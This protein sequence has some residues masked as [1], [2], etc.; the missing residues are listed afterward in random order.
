MVSQSYG[1]TTIVRA[2]VINRDPQA[3]RLICQILLRCGYAVSECDS[4]LF[5]QDEYAG[6]SLVVVD[7]RSVNDEVRDFL[8]WVKTQ[9]VGS[10]GRQPYVMAVVIGA[11]IDW[12]NHVDRSDWDEMLKM[13]D[14]VDLLRQRFEDIGSRFTRLEVA[15]E[16]LD[17]VSPF[18]LDLDS[19]V[20]EKFSQ[21]EAGGEDGSGVELSPSRV[22]E[23]N[24]LRGRASTAG[25]LPCQELFNEIAESVPY[26]LVVLGRDEKFIY[27]NARHAELLGLGIDE[28]ESMEAWLQALCAEEKTCREVTS[29]WRRHV[30]QKQLV[31][32]YTLRAV[33]GEM[34]DIEFRPKLLQDGGLLLTMI[35]VSERCRSEEA[36]L[37][38]EVKFKT[39]FGS[40][41]IGMALVDRT[42]RICT[43]NKALEQML[44]YTSVELRAMAFDD[45]V[46]VEDSGTKRDFE[47]L[48]KEEPQLAAEEVRLS[49]RK[50]GGG[51]LKVFLSIARMDEKGGPFMA[52]LVRADN[53][54]G[55]EQVG[56][57]NLQ[58]SMLQNRALLEAVPDLVILFDYSGKVEDVSPADQDESF[59]RKCS[60]WTGRPLEEV[61]PAFWKVCEN[62]GLSEL[63]FHSNEGL[64]LEF[65]PAEGGVACA[66]VAGCGRGKYMAVIRRKEQGVGGPDVIASGVLA[67]SNEADAKEVI[68]SCEWAD[69]LQTLTSLL[70]LE[71][72]A[73]PADP[74]KEKRSVLQKHQGR[75]RAIACLRAARLEPVNGGS[76]M[77]SVP[78]YLK[79]LL[80]ELLGS[81]PIVSDK[82]IEA[83]VNCVSL[84]LPARKAFA[85]G[86]YVTE[87]VSNSIEHGLANF[88][89]GQVY[90]RLR[91]SDR[92][93]VLLIGD[94]GEGLPAEF[95]WERANTLGFRVVKSL[96]AQLGARLEIRPRENTE[97]L[98][99]FPLGSD[100]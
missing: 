19:E 77:V 17:L 43:V 92:E 23:L 61:L 100:E 86:L 83:E 80:E 99:R 8:A 10:E 96:V 42:G 81:S 47:N 15:P 65:S 22:A 82:S 36:W 11:E 52:Y 20:G 76:E 56:S 34:V 98:I 90:V 44:D 78:T 5:G 73:M 31:R 21:R 2:F 62:A 35:D 6:E 59:A 68:E 89:G 95:D 57:S 12:L 85:L 74:E 97:F 14:E 1:N 79:A 13:P 75:I 67:G 27:G 18:E 40:Q 45:F 4:P 3:R 66:H 7:V 88:A 87:L 49:L 46:A 32:T 51:V 24:E 38:S 58:D 64:V 84:G 60:T 94:D 41:G 71:I 69:Q 93:A 63:E 28:A 54:E 55:A 29:S 53:K 25:A 9:K 48:A 91:R 37:L 70:N 72:E 26:G 30:W 16:S 39:L 33:G 50:N